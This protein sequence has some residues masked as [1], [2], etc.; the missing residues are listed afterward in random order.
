[1]PFRPTA[2]QVQLAAGQKRPRLRLRPL[3]HVCRHLRQPQGDRGELCQRGLPRRRRRRGV[4]HQRRRRRH[5]IRGRF[6]RRPRLV[7][8]AVLASPARLGEEES[9][10]L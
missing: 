4:D 7:A 3:R 1:M 10:G 5:L 6:R 9:H 8:A 2:V